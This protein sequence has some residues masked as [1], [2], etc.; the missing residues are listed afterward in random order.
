MFV[1]SNRLYAHS[2]FVSQYNLK[3]WSLHSDVDTPFFAGTP[4]HVAVKKH[5]KK[6]NCS[7]TVAFLLNQGADVLAQVCTIPYFCH[8]FSGLRG[9]ILCSYCK[10]CDEKAYDVG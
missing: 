1:I 3:I 8:Y 10:I 9:C 6:V 5:S 7:Q 2:L 4:L